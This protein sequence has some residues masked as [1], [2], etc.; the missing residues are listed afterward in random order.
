MLPR[1]HVINLLTV[2][3]QNIISTSSVYHRINNN[4][5]QQHISLQT[6][7]RTKTKTIATTSL[8]SVN[9]TNITASFSPSTSS[10]PQQQISFEEHYSVKTGIKTAAILGGMLFLVVLYL[11][12]KARSRL[13]RSSPTGIRNPRLSAAKFDLDYWLKQV[14]LLEAKEAERNRG[15]QSLYLELPNVDPRDNREAT[16]SWIVDAYR[17]WR[18]IQYRQRQPV[19]R[20][21][22]TEKTETN[23]IPYRR[24]R[25]LF[26]RFFRR[27]LSSSRQD[28]LYLNEH[29]Q[30]L[31]IG[32][33]PSIVSNS[34]IPPPLTSNLQMRRASSWP[35]LKSNR[36]PTGAP[37]SALQT[38]LARK[39]LLKRTSRT[40][41]DI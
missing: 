22:S 36:H 41:F 1:N 12:W 19:L 16:A 27:L 9:I 23:P 26:R 32:M 6:K 5:Q 3:P 29:S 10:T 39:R 30:A 21:N 24:R 34:F 13:C 33:R 38:H 8:I 15:D 40:T 11:L 18:L 25:Y 2:R 20:S 37:M 17:Q 4:K 31:I 14:D 7:N 28:P 35:R